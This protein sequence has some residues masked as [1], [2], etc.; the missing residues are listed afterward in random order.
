VREHIA[1]ALALGDID[2]IVIKRKKTPDLAALY[3]V[4]RVAA[5]DAPAAVERR[6][7]PPR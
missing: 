7:R 5:S 2:L 1:M 3:A 4:A 6:T